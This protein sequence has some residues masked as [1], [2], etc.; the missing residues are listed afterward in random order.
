MAGA[1]VPLVNRSK[2]L[3]RWPRNHQSGLAQGVGL[4]A[5]QLH[6]GRDHPDLDDRGHDSLSRRSHCAGTQRACGY[7]R[8]ADWRIAV[9]LSRGRSC[10]PVRSRQAASQRPVGAV[11]GRCPARRR[12]L[13]ASLSVI[14]HVWLSDAAASVLRQAVET[15][16]PSLSSC[17]TSSSTRTAGS[18]ETTSTV[19]SCSS[20]NRRRTSSICA[21]VCVSSCPVGSSSPATRL[22]GVVLSDVARPRTSSP[23]RWDPGAPLG[24]SE[25][26]SIWTSRFAPNGDHLAPLWSLLRSA[27]VKNSITRRSY[28]AGLAFCTPICSTPGSIHKRRGSPAAS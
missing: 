21:P 11:A 24:V 5:C 15:S 4:L 13:V 22:R 20:T 28:S 18:C 10:H 2:R 25:I 12:L 7:R 16:F 27:A 17:T 9:N 14:S 19:T 1:G 3:D 23:F 8:F 26:G 6:D